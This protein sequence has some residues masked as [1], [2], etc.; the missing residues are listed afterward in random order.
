[1][2]F[3]HG[4]YVTIAEVLTGLNVALINILSYLVFSLHIYTFQN[5]ILIL[6]CNINMTKKKVNI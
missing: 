3:G 4:P 5:N 6:K 1:M 2:S